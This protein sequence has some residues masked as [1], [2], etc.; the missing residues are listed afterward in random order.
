M[1]HQISGQHMDN[2][3]VLMDSL[4]T[5]ND[6]VVRPAKLTKPA[7]GPT[8]TKDLTLEVY[9]KQVRAWN[10]ASEDIP[11]NTKYHDFVES[12]KLNKEIHGLP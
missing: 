9:V 3:N 6:D 2:M 8:W 7:K 10:D 12:L 1:L 5:K 11:V 4:K